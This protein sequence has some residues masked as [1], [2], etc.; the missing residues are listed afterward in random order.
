MG[1]RIKCPCVHQIAVTI[2]G[3]YDSWDETHA[4]LTL[5]AAL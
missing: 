2:K 4:F 5:T 3:A 1:C